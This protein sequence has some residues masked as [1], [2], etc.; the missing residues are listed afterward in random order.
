MEET[1][2]ERENALLHKL[3]LNIKQCRDPEWNRIEC[4]G[5]GVRGREIEWREKRSIQEP[6]AS[7][8]PIHQP[9]H[10]YYLN[11]GSGGLSVDMTPRSLTLTPL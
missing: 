9:I 1:E 3:K 5:S 7:E 8:G 6:G 2:R 10:Y 4:P 11:K